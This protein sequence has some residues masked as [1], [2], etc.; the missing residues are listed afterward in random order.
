MIEV[1]TLERCPQ[2]GAREVRDRWEAHDRVYRAT[3]DRFLYARCQRCG[4]YFLRVRPTSATVGELYGDDYSPYVCGNGSSLEA[5]PAGR[6]DRALGRGRAAWRG[7]VAETYVLPA[8]GGRLLDFGC[9]SARFL[10]P[11][12]ERG[13]D[14]T[15]ADFSPAVV[16][17]VR[18]EGF[19]C[20]TVDDLWDRPPSVRFDVVRMNHVL[21]HL[22]DPGQI[23]HLLLS[24][25]NTGGRL[26]AAVPNPGSV[27]AKVFGTYWRGLEPRHVLLYPPVYLRSM[28]LGTG[29]KQV[30][31]RHEAA[32]RDW[33]GSLGYA[34]DGRS[35]FLRAAA[36]HPFAGR[37]SSLA[38]STAALAGAGDR[39][40]AVATR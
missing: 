16:E 25:M 38:A 27:S 13:W 35:A 20:S 1:E 21:E 14:V 18:A 31:I 4:V 36:R 24:R 39:L 40:H 19:A 33:L 2:C 30:E 34:V 7:L 11:A 10:R 17:R 8:G 32:Q 23:L 6:L 9:G 26:H 28:L 12:A 37:L 22:Y 29:F 5:T 15:G 3:D